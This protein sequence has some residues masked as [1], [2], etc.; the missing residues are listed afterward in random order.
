MFFT[1]INI[2]FFSLRFELFSI[3]AKEVNWIR[4][5]VACVV[6][7]LV[8]LFLLCT[9]CGPLRRK[10]EEFG[11]LG[12]VFPNCYFLW[13]RWQSMC[14]ETSIVYWLAFIFSKH[15]LAYLT[16][17]RSEFHFVI[18]TERLFGVSTMEFLFIM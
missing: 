12:P 2:S 8:F 15:I 3:I 7:R 17:Y 10:L 18:W 11:V 6:A 14:Y 9:H 5:N 16:E 1:I 4:N 13:L